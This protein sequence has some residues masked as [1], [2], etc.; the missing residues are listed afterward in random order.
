MTENEIRRRIW[1]NIWKSRGEPPNAGDYAYW[2]RTWPDLEARG[3]EISVPD[4]ADRRMLGWQAGGAD[5]ARF[6]EYASSRT[7]Y[8]DVPPYPGDEAPASSSPPPRATA[9]AP[10]STA[11]IDA[12]LEE[13]KRLLN[14]LLAQMGPDYAGTVKLPK[15]L[16]SRPAAI[17]LRAVKK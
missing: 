14:E 12:R 3:Q 9:E 1:T 6:G 13:I 7:P 4:Y 11:A 5:V 10:A 15:S 8:H 16:T 2:M 17:S